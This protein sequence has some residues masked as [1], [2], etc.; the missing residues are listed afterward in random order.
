MQDLVFSVARF[1]RVEDSIGER[2]G[3]RWALPYLRDIEAEEEE[4][5]EEEGEGLAA[6]ELEV[7]KTADLFQAEALLKHCLEGFYITIT[8]YDSSGYS[9]L[10]Q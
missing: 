5:E 8:K 4:G 10:S 1:S 3:W 9:Q 2:K 7:L 6:L